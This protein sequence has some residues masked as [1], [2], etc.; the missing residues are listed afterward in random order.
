MTMTKLSLISNIQLVY[1]TPDF[2]H[3]PKLA[4]N[5]LGDLKTIIPPEGKSISWDYFV[6]VYSLLQQGLSLANKSVNTE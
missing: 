5:A 4:Q 3:M 6:H 1:A 2:C